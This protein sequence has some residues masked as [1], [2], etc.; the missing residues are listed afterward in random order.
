MSAARPQNRPS[1]APRNRAMRLPTTGEHSAVIVASAEAAFEERSDLRRP[2]S[3]CVYEPERRAVRVHTGGASGGRSAPRLLRPPCS[4]SRPAQW[5]MPHRP[6]RSRPRPAVAGLCGLPPVG[7]SSS[8]PSS[9]LPAATLHKL[10]DAEQWRRRELRTHYRMLKRLREA[11][12]G[13]QTGPA[14]P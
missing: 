1:A 4:P 7:D 6:G 14:R 9:W 13:T 3:G 8:S 10:R 5:P 11:Q 12:K 2:A